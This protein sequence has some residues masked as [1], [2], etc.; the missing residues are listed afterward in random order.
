MTNRQRLFVEEYLRCGNATEAAIKAGYSKKT[1]YSIGSENLRKP[2]IAAIIQQRLSDKT[3][4]ANEVLERLTAQARGNLAPFLVNGKWFDLDSD[5]AKA[6]IDLIKKAKFKR[7]VVNDTTVDEEV[8][9]E[10]YDAQSALVWMGK[11]HKLFTE[12]VAIDGEIAVKAYVGISPDDWD[13]QE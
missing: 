10:L 8:E 11:H 1:A 9:I 6:N 13:K 5:S 12:N 2:E 3:M 4:A 7:R